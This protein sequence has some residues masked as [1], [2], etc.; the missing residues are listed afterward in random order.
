MEGW[1]GL[2]WAGLGQDRSQVGATI[3]ARLNTFTIGACWVKPTL[4]RVER[5]L[6]M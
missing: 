6:P 4:F 2:G 5:F 1:T 3:L